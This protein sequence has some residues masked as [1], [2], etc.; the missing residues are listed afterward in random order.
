MRPWFDGLCR[1]FA[2]R[3]V[4]AGVYLVT[5]LAA[6]PLATAMGSAMYEHL[7]ASLAADEA[8]DS[9]N[10]DWWQEFA[11]QG[12]FLSLTSTFT[13]SIVGFA[14]TLDSTSSLLDRRP[15]VPAIA[16]ALAFYVLAWLFLQGGALDRIARGHRIG[17]DGFFAASGTFFFRFL[18]LGVVAGLV[19]WFL[20]TYVHEWLFAK[21]YVSATRDLAVERTAFYWRALMY[22]IF[23]ALLS[24]TALVFDYTKV[25]AVVEDRRSMV[26]ALIAAV[27]FIVR[28]P[29]RVVGLYLLNAMLFLVV[30]AVWA[31]VAPGAGGS[32]ASMWIG[33]VASQ[34]YILAR[35]VVKLQVLASET[36][37]FQQSLAHWGY[38]AAPLAVEREPP[39]VRSA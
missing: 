37:L 31:I 38:T 8:A 2:A 33:V 11:S 1:I 29:S 3:A 26:G 18:R 12:S 23:T 20:F 13:P 36:A 15:M 39:L 9:V 28:H 22:A 19:Y 16:L 27:R 25:R 34:C 35:L 6:V 17:A 4:I 7:G 10:Y 32:G 30:V 14:T 24:S 5:L 21:W